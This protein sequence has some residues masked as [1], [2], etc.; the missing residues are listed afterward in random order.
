MNMPLLDPKIF[1]TYRDFI[2]YK[3]ITKPPS[4]VSVSVK[5]VK[6]S[7]HMICRH[8]ASSITSSHLIIHLKGTRDFDFTSPVSVSCL[9][10][11]VQPD[12]VRCPL[13]W[14]RLDRDSV[15]CLVYMR[16][17]RER[18]NITNI[19]MTSTN[20]FSLNITYCKHCITRLTV[21]WCW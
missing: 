20:K 4:E 1:Q 12:V 13:L 8:C 19:W 11:C 2:I 3:F 21:T 14:A 9:C 10:S 18:T 17:R 5:S 16:E 6:N 15:I 7:L